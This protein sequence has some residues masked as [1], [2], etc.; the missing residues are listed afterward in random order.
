MKIIGI[1]EIEIT[2]DENDTQ[3]TLIHEAKKYF[4]Y[5]VHD[6]E[7]YAD[8]LKWKIKEDE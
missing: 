5:A 2:E 4:N 7:M 6:K 1:I 8:R 3:E